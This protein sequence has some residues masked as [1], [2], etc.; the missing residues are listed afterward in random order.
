[1][2]LLPIGEAAAALGVAP[3]T[4]RYYDERGL[5]APAE[6]RGGRRYYGEEEVRRLALLTLVHR[7]GVPLALAAA[8]LD[9][10]RDRWQQEVER[11]VEQLDDLVD[12]AR[13]A[14]RFLTAALDC[15]TDHPASQCASLRGALDQMVAGKTVGQL[16]AEHP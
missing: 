9:E 13:G 10:P 1:M 3:S 8:V 4:L 12:R 16:A 5:L 11:Q 2:T 6:R 7:L 14:Q 15:P